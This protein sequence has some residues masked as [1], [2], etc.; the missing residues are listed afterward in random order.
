MHPMRRK[1]REVRDPA[2]IREILD[3]CTVCHIGLQDG[4]GVYIV[5]LN[6]GLVENNGQYRFYF[7][8]DKQGRKMDLIGD[9]VKAGFQLETGT[10]LVPG[11]EAKDCTYK[12]QSIIGTGHIAPVLDKTEKIQALDALMKQYRGEGDWTYPDRLID[13][14]GILRLDVEEL[15]CKEYQ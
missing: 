3:K 14:V 9:G 6:F 4:D 5:P 2:H 13:L 12:F 8:G 7:H 11:Q 15:S 10:E 1:D